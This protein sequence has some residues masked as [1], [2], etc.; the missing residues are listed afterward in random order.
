MGL[1]NVIERARARVAAN[2]GYAGELTPVEAWEILAQAGNAVLI[3]CR[4]G[5][6]WGYVG[7]AD[8]SSLGKEPVCVPWK[9][10]PTMA[11]NPEF[12]SQV[13]QRGAGRDGPL[14][15]MCRSGVRSKAAAM[16]MTAAGFSPCFNLVEGFEGD[17]D[18]AGHRGTINGW[19]V[20]GLPWKQS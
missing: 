6:E 1:E 4:T 8:L 2:A 16:A 12:V 15:F 11:V 10:F 14:I 20:R 5:P 17:L 19:K 18:A 9:T 7:L 3:D 13:A